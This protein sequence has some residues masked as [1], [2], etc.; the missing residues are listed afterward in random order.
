ML[1]PEKGSYHNLDR[2][3][4]SRDITLLTKV[5]IVKTMVFPVVVYRCKN[6][7]IRKAEYQRTNAFKLWCWRRLE[8][9]L[10]NKEIKTVNP[11]GN[12]SWIFIRRTDAEAE[13]PIFWPPDVKSW[14]TGKDPDVAKEEGKRRRG[15]QRMRWLDCIPQL[16]GHECQQTQGDS[17][18]QGSIVCCSSWGCKQLGHN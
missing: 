9:P 18:G 16:N 6:W 3:L 14:L 13:A 10:D 1:T 7:T 12:Q 8:S 2:V 15:W 5:C 11:K 17:E 4:K